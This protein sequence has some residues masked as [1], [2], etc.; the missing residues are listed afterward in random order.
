MKIA[1]N[2]NIRCKA[3]HNASVQKIC[4]ISDN[5]ES[6]GIGQ[7]FDEKLLVVTTPGFIFCDFEL[8]I[9]DG[10][11]SPSQDGPT[12]TPSAAICPSDDIIT[13]LDKNAAVLWHFDGEK[14]TLSLRF[15]PQEV[16]QWLAMDTDVIAGISDAKQ[17]SALF[18]RNIISDPDAVAESQWV[19]EVEQKNA[20]KLSFD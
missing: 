10:F 7:F 14:G 15:G 20:D 3:F 11:G 6:E 16:S 8:D 12:D 5:M 4:L 2:K 13:G 19:D 18:I 1:W 17:L 9:S